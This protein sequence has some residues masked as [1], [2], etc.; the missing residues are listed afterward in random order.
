MRLYTLETRYG[1]CKSGLLPWFD[2]PE[3]ERPMRYYGWHWDP[4]LREWVKHAEEPIEIKYT[5]KAGPKPS[6]PPRPEVPEF[7]D[8]WFWSKINECW[9]KRPM[10]KIENWR[11]PGELPWPREPTWVPSPELPFESAGWKYNSRLRKWEMVPY[12]EY[13][14]DERPP[15]PAYPPGPAGETEVYGWSWFP[16]YKDWVEV[17]YAE[18]VVEFQMSETVNP[19][20]TEA[21]VENVYPYAEIAERAMRMLI[22]A[23]YTPEQAKQY[24][25]TVIEMV[26]NQVMAASRHVQAGRLAQ[27]VKATKDFYPG[28]E[29]EFIMPVV[30]GIILVLTAWVVGRIMGSLVLPEEEDVFI[31]QK[32]TT[33]LMGPDEWIY[34]GF[35]AQTVKGTKYFQACGSIGTPYVRH[36]RGYGVGQTDIIDFPGGFLE[37]GWH[38]GLFVKYVWSYWKLSY[39]GFLNN[40]GGGLYSLQGSTDL[41][42]IAEYAS[43]VLDPDVC[44][45]FT[46]EYL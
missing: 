13:T 16:Y 45:N 30:V 4:A 15:E 1:K 12:C 21:M 20:V 44:W 2:P 40:V 10:P 11:Y 19:A 26:R 17:L 35:K 27:A 38:A 34:A 25:I 29:A 33:Y 24:G 39:V 5:P 36:K 14:E 28:V 42:F 7:V 3:P 9:E 18:K 32:K 8:G 46:E 31:A 37:E 6:E 41:E 22:H 23:G 43:V